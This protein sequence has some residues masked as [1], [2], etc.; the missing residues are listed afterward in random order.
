MELR[1]RYLILG[2][3]VLLV[4][5]ATAFLLV[6]QL[7]SAGDVGAST[8]AGT[9]LTPCEDDPNVPEEE[10]RE[11]E[12]KIDKHLDKF[13]QNSM[14]GSGTFCKDGKYYDS[15]GKEIVND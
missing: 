10:K 7:T 9:T 14:D 11:I 15:N 5:A 12:A 3:A 6:R 8:V 4:L 2:L 1:S 13:K